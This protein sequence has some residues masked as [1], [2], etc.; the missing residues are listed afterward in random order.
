LKNQLNGTLDISQSGNG[1]RLGIE[2]FGNG[3]SSGQTLTVTQTG[4]GGGNATLVPDPP[5]DGFSYYYP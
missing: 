3:A 5:P 1:S 2:N 4:P